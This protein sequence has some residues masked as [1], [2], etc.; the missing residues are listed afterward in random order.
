M[1]NSLKVIE[2]FEIIDL[3]EQEIDV[4]DLEVEDNNNF[5]AKIQYRTNNL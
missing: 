3:G 4:Y 5:F 1:N 2:N